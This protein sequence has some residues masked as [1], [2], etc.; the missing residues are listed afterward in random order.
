MATMSER[1]VEEFLRASRHAIVATNRA[2]GSPQISPVWYIHD[3]GRLYITVATA[4]A[5]YRNLRRD[6]RVSDCIDGCHP[7]TR[8]VAVAGT[9]ELI[10]DVTPWFDDIR[11][12]IF[13]RYRDSDEA[14]DR[15]LESVR[16]R[17][18][19][20]IVVAPEKIITRVPE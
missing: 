8:Y 3:D 13:R 7:D 11:W 6:P 15:Y 10:D 12:R 4:S 1:E 2:D 19:G 14:A 5:K 16:E 9:A 20:L 18:S 17:A